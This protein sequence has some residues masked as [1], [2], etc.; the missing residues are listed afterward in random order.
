MSKPTASTQPL[1]GPQP[2]VRQAPRAGTCPPGIVDSAVTSAFDVWSSVVRH[3]VDYWCGALERGATPFDVAADVLEWSSVVARRE[4]PTW[5]TPHTVVREWP[6]ARLRDF[7]PKRPRGRAAGVPVLVLPPQAGHDSCIV[8]YAEGQSQVRTALDA[9]LTRVLSLDWVGATPAT[10]DEGVEAYLAVMREAVADLGGT[11]HLVGDC[12]GGWLAVIYTAL[13]PETVATLT[14]AGA[15]VDFHAGEPLIHDWIQLLSPDGR[16]D[17]YRALVAAGDGV[18][19][20]QV[21]LDG[22]KAMQPQGETDRQLGVLA[23]LDDPAYLARYA[24]F[25]NWFQH[26]QPIP[27]AFYLWI[28]E[29]LFQRNELVAGTLVVEGRIV[30]L[31]AISCPLYLLAGSSDHITPPPQ[32]F[33]LADFASTPADDVT[34]LVVP[35]GHLGLF[36]GHEALRGHWAPVFTAIA[37]RG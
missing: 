14:I 32:V 7:S 22:F 16:M 23:H 5:T 31:A 1:D 35:G 12:Q 33:A 36:M 3:S 37:A 11:V 4:P 9:G 8:D 27:G 19:P 24:T 10:K 2:T 15:P 20:G 6:V 26:T 28:V 29:H 30:D 18:L 13:H 21:L 34:R 25:E 17:F